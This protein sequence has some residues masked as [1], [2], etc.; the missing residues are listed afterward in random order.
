MTKPSVEALIAA[1]VRVNGG[2][3]FLLRT[4]TGAR[5]VV[6]ARHVVGSGEAQIVHPERSYT[7]A[8]YASSEDDLAVLPDHD[9]IPAVIGLEITS[10]MPPPG[11]NLVIAGFP[12]G[13]KAQTP[14]LG[15]AILAGAAEGQVWIQA[16][17]TW[18]HSGGPVIDSLGR[19]VGMVLRRAGV[20]S[21][22]LGEFR[23]VASE[24]QARIAAA[25]IAHKSN[26]EML[27][28]LKLQSSKSALAQV[29]SG[30]SEGMLGMTDAMHS[31]GDVV[32]AFVEMTSSLIDQHFRTG[33]L[34]IA[35]ADQVES[36]LGS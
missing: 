23:R 33:Y 13:W 4:P 25:R 3:G 9:Q 20:S 22:D 34:Q 7:A 1:T 15:S 26:E 17:G 16:D 36:L 28:L 27:H 19:V 29:S 6:T 8:I 32:A 30:V 10:A 21:T 12:D 14:L 24:M 31:L 2:T 18:G 11:S 35:T 5:V